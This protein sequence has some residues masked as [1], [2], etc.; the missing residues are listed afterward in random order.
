MGD[1]EFEDMADQ[2]STYWCPIIIISWLPSICTTRNL[3]SM[4]DLIIMV[5]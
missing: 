2:L 4:L 3:G 1:V 5:L